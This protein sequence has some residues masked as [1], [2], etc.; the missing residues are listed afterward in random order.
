MFYIMVTSKKLDQ[1]YH[2]LS[3]NL[4]A[5][6]TLAESLK[7][8]KGIPQQD[9]FKLSD[10]LLAGENLD[11]VVENA[12]SWLPIS[13]RYL[14]SAA[15]A[16][17]KLP[18]TFLKLGEQHKRNAKN[19]SK[20]IFATIYPLAVLHFGIFIFPVFSL[21]EFN[22]ESEVQTHFARYFVDVF[23]VLIPLWLV[24]GSAIYLYIKR[25]PILKKMMNVIPG[26]KGYSK[27]QAL[28]SFC[29]TLEAFMSAGATT[30]ESWYGASI[31]SG[32]PKI[33]DAMLDLSNDIKKGVSPGNRMAQFKCFPKDFETFYTAGERTGQL[34]E[35]LGVLAERF[36]EQANQ[37]I[38]MISF[39]IP[40]LMF[41]L[42]AI[43]MATQI[44]GFFS[45]YVDNIMNMGK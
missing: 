26:I 3:Q 25:S 41:L 7:L 21:I 44:M 1:W 45:G 28:A 18:Q 9:A 8:S 33:K 6:L 13:D 20:F 23:K 11:T 43:Y 24:I 22:A 10:K 12:P 16:T 31:A 35:N 4:E 42:L 19:I 14:I 39:W 2:Q 38:A 17:G 40:K 29:F 15:G 37:K 27:N 30:I 36:Q 5:G 34:V 32:D